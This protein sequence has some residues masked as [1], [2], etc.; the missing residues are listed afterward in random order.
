M[1]VFEFSAAMACMYNSNISN[2]R[3]D[4][5]S[6]IDFMEFVMAKTTTTTINTFMITPKKDCAIVSFPKNSKNKQTNGLRYC[7][8][9]WYC[10]R[11]CGGLTVVIGTVEESS[12]VSTG[13][14]TIVVSS[15]VGVPGVVVIDVGV[16]SV[17]VGAVE[18]FF[19]DSTVVVTIVVSSLV[20]VTG[21]V[22]INVGVFSIVVDAVEGFSVVSTVV[23][24]IVVSSL[25][26]VTGV[27]VINVG[28]FSVVVDAVEGFSVV[29]T[30]VVTIVVSSLVEVT[31]VV[32]ICKM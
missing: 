8:R 23:V 25:V 28:V 21:V 5:L 24:T 4:S 20:E 9:L 11:C 22:V 30:V 26:E 17:V 1:P 15:L 27:V 6:C 2:W 29:S 19:V 13:V 10:C 16:F 12:V 18:G 3:R 32:V 31:G 14:V 7:G